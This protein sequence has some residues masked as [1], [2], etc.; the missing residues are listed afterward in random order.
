MEKI[1]LDDISS[2]FS[3]IIFTLRD[4]ILALGYED[5]SYIIRCY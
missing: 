4:F 3:I 1:V 5:T 2:V